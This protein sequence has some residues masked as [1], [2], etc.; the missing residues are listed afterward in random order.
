MQTEHAKARGDR[1][2]WQLA[3]AELTARR[4]LVVGPGDG[5]VLTAEQVQ[6]D[7]A[8]ELGDLAFRRVPNAARG[9]R[10]K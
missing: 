8:R 1:S 4:D 6:R 10:R 7:S 3:A 5:Q 2:E 9:E